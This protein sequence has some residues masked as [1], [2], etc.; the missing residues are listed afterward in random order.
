MIKR[1]WV[2]V[3]ATIMLMLAGNAYSARVT[4]NFSGEFDSGTSAAEPLIGVGD[5]YNGYLTFDILEDDT[6]SD[7]SGNLTV[8][9]YSTIFTGFDYS[10]FPTLGGSD[11]SRRY[12]E[13]SLDPVGGALGEYQISSMRFM[14][15]T[16]GM[17]RHVRTFQILTSD[18]REFLS[19]EVRAKRVSGRTTSYARLHDFDPNGEAV[20][21]VS[22]VPLPAALPLYGAG[23]AILGLVGWIRKTK[24]VG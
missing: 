24:A 9:G 8:N 1:I 7:V 18:R 10:H 2:A 19:T 13:F 15:S 5:T 4:I 3:L 11:Y 23:I 21:G 12:L 16:L 17:G 6:I 22:V 20:I 14:F